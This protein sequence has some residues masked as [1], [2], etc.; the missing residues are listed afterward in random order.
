MTSNRAG[1]YVHQPSGYKAFLPTPLPPDPP[2]AVDSELWR[3]TSKADRSLG[4]LDGA[5]EILPN[6]DLFVA[7]YARKEAVLSSQI[8]GTQ[9]S[10]TDLI[11]FEAGYRDATQPYD[12]AEVW[13]Y[14][15]AMHHGLSRL[16]TLPVSLRLM[17][18]IHEKLMSGVRGQERNPG[19]F[20]TSQNW[21]GPPGCTL[22]EAAFVPPPP[23]ELM[24]SLGAL[25][26]FVHQESDLPALVKIGLIH[27]QFET[28]HPFLDGNGRVGR[29]LITFL[30]CAQGILRWP[31]L[32]LSYYFEKH[33]QEYYD[34]LQAVRDRGDWEGWLRFFLTGVSEVSEQA[35]ATSRNIV[36]LREAHRAEALA[37]LGRSSGNGLRLL[38]L[39]YE[40]PI[41]DV[42]L[43]EQRLNVTYATSNQLVARLREA[44]ILTEISGKARGRLFAYRQYLDLFDGE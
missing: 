39:L 36:A 28:I 6:R 31:S 20:R 26:T 14:L 7:M 42:R 19:E 37:I 18:E 38:E 10:L 32:Y 25:E 1:R 35:I 12:V 17:R 34:R 5:S 27:A 24:N 23:S 2:L 29:L 22:K 9:A 15:D 43:V 11:E 33:R 30:L 13:N 44:G 8:E 4:R 16:E 3:L 40:V 21:I 41:V